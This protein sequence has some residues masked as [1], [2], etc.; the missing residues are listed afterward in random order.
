[1][2]DEE[3]PRRVPFLIRLFSRPRAPRKVLY[4]VFSFT[5]IQRFFIF[6]M[7]FYF[8][9]L[10]QPRA[11]RPWEKPKEEPKPEPKPERSWARKTDSQSSLSVDPKPE[12]PASAPT[13]TATEA[14]V[15]KAEGTGGKV[16]QKNMKYFK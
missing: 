14:E 5:F 8:K 10:L 7:S 6:W 16:C 13:P 2:S 9:I 15:T 1:M 11:S 12:P 4:N 3:I